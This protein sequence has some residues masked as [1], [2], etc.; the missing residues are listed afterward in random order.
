LVTFE[1]VADQRRRASGIARRFA[2][3]DAGEA[4]RYAEQGGIVGK[5]VLEP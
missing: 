1:I 2:L 4:L 5:V 3:R